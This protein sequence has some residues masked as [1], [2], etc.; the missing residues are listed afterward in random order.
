MPVMTNENF[1]DGPTGGQ[2]RGLLTA[3]AK[4]KQL[5]GQVAIVTGGAQGIGAAFGQALA[6]AGAAVALADIADAGPAVAEIVAAGGQAMAV[7]LDVCEPK[8]IAAA[9]EQVSARF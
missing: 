5:E 8:S 6:Q 9:L 2:I 1:A 7:K 4:M 3:K